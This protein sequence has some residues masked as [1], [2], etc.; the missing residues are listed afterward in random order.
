MKEPGKKLAKSKELGKKPAKPKGKAKNPDEPRV[1]M[2]ALPFRGDGELEIMLVSS[3]GTRRW[4]IPKG[5]P[6]KG[7]KPYEA[8]AIEA[9]EEAG[10]VGA[11][12]KQPIGFY[13]YRKRMKNGASTLCRV[14]VY[15]MRVTRQRKNWLERRQRVTRWFDLAEASELVEEEELQQLIRN[16]ST[17]AEPGDGPRR[18]KA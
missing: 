5:W 2:G 16:F 6:M 1:Q 9:L 15:P 11:V 17:A 8:A 7:R 12:R 14:D 3:R 10:L 4:V 13:H 18:V